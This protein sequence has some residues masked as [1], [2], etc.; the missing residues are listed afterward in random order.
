MSQF[1]PWHT[2]AVSRR[3]TSPSTASHKSRINP[4]QSR[5]TLV[6]HGPVPWEGSRTHKNT[7][8]ILLST[9]LGDLLPCLSGCCCCCPDIPS[10]YIM[11]NYKVARVLLRGWGSKRKTE[12]EKELSWSF[13]IYFRHLFLSL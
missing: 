12:T 3:N 13:L 11:V 7:S 4:A 10:H 8:F 6:K 5:P 1:I 2:A 9:H